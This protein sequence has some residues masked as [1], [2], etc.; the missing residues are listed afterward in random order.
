MTS[1]VFQKSHAHEYF[2]SKS[3][4]SFS[5]NVSKV[6]FRKFAIFFIKFPVFEVIFSNLINR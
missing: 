1:Q 2:F 3:C 6:I 5:E 4:V